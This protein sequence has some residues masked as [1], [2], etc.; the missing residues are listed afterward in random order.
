MII[1]FLILLLVMFVLG[2]FSL[3]LAMGV[4]TPTERTH[5]H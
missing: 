2:L 1:P 5:Q 4:V 3:I